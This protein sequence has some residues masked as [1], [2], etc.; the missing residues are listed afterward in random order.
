MF[1]QDFQVS[2][3]PG[4]EV[5]DSARDYTRSDGW[6]QL[7][8]QVE[9]T[10]CQE[11]RSRQALD[12]LQQLATE[13]GASTQFLLKSVIRETIRITME[14]LSEAKQMLSFAP[15]ARP[16]VTIEKPDRTE[17]QAPLRSRPILTPEE[18]EAQ[19]D[20][21][22]VS[23][24]N[25]A[26]KPTRSPA[27]IDRLRP[28]AAPKESPELRLQRSIEARDSSLRDLCDR[29]HTQ[30]EHLG[31]DLRKIHSET[32]IALHYLQA[33][34]EGKIDRLPEDVYLRGFLRRLEKSL[35]LPAGDLTARL[36][37][38]IDRLGLTANRQ[39]LDP[40]SIPQ[41]KSVI[42]SLSFQPNYAYLTYAALMT[43]GVF[44]V[45]QQG[46][47]KSNFTP[48][49]IDTPGPAPA[50]VIQPKKVS[51]ESVQKVQIRMSQNFSSP[52]VMM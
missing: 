10:L 8:A 31:L 2:S 32:F 36:P 40:T 39:A 14:C 3:V 42:P 50:T 18:K 26:L 45:S 9:S 6:K 27:L 44:W 43:S 41:Q 35:H 47:P 51:S 34:D 16:E 52:E 4:S 1:S 48:I 13:Q 28:P 30:R 49:K 24:L 23:A 11:D 15:S 19:E 33:L 29:I 12:Q 20:M 7:V 46:S 37:Q 38:P 17:S 5:M 21:A 22:L 25:H